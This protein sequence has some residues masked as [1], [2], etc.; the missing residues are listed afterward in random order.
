MQNKVVNII[1]Y[2]AQ[3]SLGVGAIKNVH[4]GV[5]RIIEEAGADASDN[6][7]ET[8]SMDH[9]HRHHGMFHPGDLFICLQISVVDIVVLQ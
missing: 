7:F 5:M 1:K 2:I 4:M 9:M 8:I 6:H 3:H